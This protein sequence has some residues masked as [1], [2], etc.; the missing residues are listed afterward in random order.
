MSIHGHFVM[1]ITGDH[2]TPVDYGDHRYV[3]MYVCMYVCSH[4]CMY[5]CMYVCICHV[6]MY[7]C[8]CHTGM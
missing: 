8:I 5:V 7:V 4:V 6:C 1:C 3:V 2:S